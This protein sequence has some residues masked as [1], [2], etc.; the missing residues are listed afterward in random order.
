MGDARRIEAAGDGST[1]WPGV[2]P[3]AILAIL[4]FAQLV[5]WTLIPTLVQPNPPLDVIEG[6]TWGREW[7]WGYHRHPPLQAWLLELTSAATGKATWGFYLLSQIAVAAALWFVWRLAE[8]ILG[9]RGAIVATL[10]LTG[11]YYFSAPTPEFNPNILQLP[12][13]AGLG[14]AFHCALIGGSLGAWLATGVLAALSLYTKYSAALLIACLAAVVVIEPL[15]R[16]RLREVGPYLA[17]GLTFILYAPHL[18]WL[19][20]HDFMPMAYAVDRARDARSAIDHLVFPLQFLGGQLL[21]HAGLAAILTGAL[22]GIGRPPPPRPALRLDVSARYIAYVALGPIL[23]ALLSSALLGQRYR[24]MWGAPFFCFSGLLAAI[25]L[26]QLQSPASLR[27]VII[28][29]AAVFFAML[30]GFTMTQLGLPHVTGQARSG[31]YP[32]A[33]TAKSLE[34]LWRE[35]V[36]TELR[37]VVGATWE[38]GNAAL[39]MRS[40]PSVLIGGNWTTSPW[41]HPED[42]ARTGAL[43]IWNLDDR[44]GSSLPTELSRSFSGVRTQPTL[45][46]GWGTSA[47][48]PPLELGWAIVPPGS[49][50]IRP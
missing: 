31:H 30:A 35:Q 49:R 46:F 15:G 24:T 38:A 27:R 4:L 22:L 47:K 12:L 50:V 6:M 36:G 44:R 8:D 10:P 37:Y 28:S 16:R 39:H 34:A 19:V 25:L 9:A 32:G 42:V 41:V 7:Q 11:L 29:S 21:A 43:I 5:L 20:D 26:P 1:E 23:I 40:R 18:V 14:Y 2:A 33:A 3:R 13:W 45:S 48:L 17:A